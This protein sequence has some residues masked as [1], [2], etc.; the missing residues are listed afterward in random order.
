MTRIIAWAVTM[1]LVT[2]AAPARGEYIIHITQAGPNVV[3]AGSGTLNLAAV[4]ELGGSGQEPVLNP[5]IAAIFVGPT[6]I[7]QEYINISGPS[8]FGSGGFTF[9]DS[10]AGQSA[11]IA[12]NE[13]FGYPGFE[14]P[15]GYVSGSSLAGS[16]TFDNTTLKGLGLTLG[17]YTWTW[18]SGPTAD[19]FEVVIGAPA[20]APEPS[21]LIL[22]G[23]AIG[24]VGFPSWLRRRQAA[25]AAAQPD[26]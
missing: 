26:P 6:V 9:A 25:A 20:V 17:T 2:L 3:A 15:L 16:A 23:T 1:I 21:S 24:V 7:E 14:V 11:G 12:G 13:G 19:S 18:G 4:Q 5:S 8:T 10:S 22:V